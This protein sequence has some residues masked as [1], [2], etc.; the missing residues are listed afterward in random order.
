MS[1]WLRDDR[2]MATLETTLMIVIL[3]PLLFAILEFGWLTQRWLAQDGVALQAAR[4][5]GELGGDGPELRDYVQEQLRLVGIE[6]ARVIVEV[7]PASVGW[8]QPVRVSLRTDER[9]AVPFLLT[10]TVTVRSTAVARGEVS[11]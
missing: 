5:A 7:D 1:G 6:P 9:V 4:L 3:V 2:G 11:R 10:T 8:R